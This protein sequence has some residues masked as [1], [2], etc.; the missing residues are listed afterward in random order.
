MADFDPDEYLAAGKSDDFDPDEYL[1]TKKENP[2]DVY[3]PPRP[4]DTFGHVASKPPVALDPNYQ[5]QG[6]PIEAMGDQDERLKQKITNRLLQLGDGVAMGWAPQISG[7]MGVLGEHIAEPIGKVLGGRGFDDNRSILQQYREARDYAA[8]RI[9]QAEM[10]DPA[11]QTKFAGSVAG[12]TLAG[13]PLKGLSLIGQGAL[14]GGLSALGSSDADLTLGEWSKGLKDADT[15]G[16]IGGAISGGIQAVGSG[17]GAVASASKIG[18]KAKMA[19]GRAMQKPDSV[20]KRILGQTES[21]ATSQM[22]S[23][24]AEAVEPTA[25]TPLEFKGGNADTGAVMQKQLGEL[26][27]VGDPS[28]SYRAALAYGDDEVQA[29]A[30]RNA[31]FKSSLAAENKAKQDELMKA[32]REQKTGKLATKGSPPSDAA[33]SQSPRPSDSPV[34]RQQIMDE[35]RAEIAARA[36]KPPANATQPGVPQTPDIGDYTNRSTIFNRLSKEKQAAI[37]MDNAGSD[38]MFWQ[39]SDEALTG[40]PRAK[41]MPIDDKWTA[42]FPEPTFL[43]SEHKP[44]GQDSGQFLL[45]QIMNPQH[46]KTA[47]LA[48]EELQRKLWQ[49]KLQNQRGYINFG[50]AYAAVQAIRKAPA[51]ASRAAAFGRRMEESGA[52]QIRQRAAK[53]AQN[54]TILKR[55]ATQEGPIGNAARW[56]LSGDAKGLAARTFVLTMQPQFQEMFSAPESASSPPTR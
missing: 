5:D 34:R 39:R 1:G 28:K 26:A 27:K 31:E 21:P 56:A 45:D 16:A 20:I 49:Q 30:A 51:V 3:G 15:G 22:Q 40:A 19:L 8:K 47:L 41:D 12:A 38:P 35:I 37:K 18:P 25:R 17:I 54:P 52:E 6:P 4:N 48:S 36:N 53:A 46:D 11:P 33:V 13:I 32:F 7:A 29:A 14:L 55:L 43:G 42:D 10:E 23:Q 9:K 24:A 44:M 2:Y 50:D